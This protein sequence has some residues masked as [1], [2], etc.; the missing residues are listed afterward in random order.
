MEAIKPCPF[1]GGNAEVI[2][3]TEACN[4]GA[5][6][7]ECHNCHASGPVVFG[8]KDDPKPHAI[9]MWNRRKSDPTSSIDWAQRRGYRSLDSTPQ[10]PRCPECGYTKEDAAMWLD[11][12]RC[13]GA[14]PAADSSVSEH[15]EIRS[16]A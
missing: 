13:K 2:D 14:I 11:H 12:N 3:A 6:V 7:V 15:S 5:V 8:V 10:S 16:E 4:Q 9:F 1:C